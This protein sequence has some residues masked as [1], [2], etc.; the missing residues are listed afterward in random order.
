MP[1]KFGFGNYI[2]SVLDDLKDLVAHE[3][4]G[5]TTT[6]GDEG[7]GKTNLTKL[8]AY[9]VDPKIS[10]EDVAFNAAQF[11]AAVDKADE[12]SSIIWDESDDLSA[13]WAST[14]IQTLKKKFKRIRSK[15]LFIWLVTPTFFDMNKYWAIHRT[16]CLFHVYAEPK[17]DSDGHFHANRGRVRFF[18]KDNKR[19]LYFGGVKN[20]DMYCIHPDFL[21]AFNKVPDDYPINNKDYEDKK[22]EAMKSLLA[23]V[24]S[25]QSRNI[26]EILFRRRVIAFAKHIN[27]F[28]SVK[29]K[30]RLSCNDWGK[31][32]FGVNKK[33]IAN[34]IHFLQRNNVGT[35]P[36]PYYE[37]G[38]VGSEGVE[39]TSSKSSLPVVENDTEG[40]EVEP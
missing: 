20:W 35:S 11:E 29:H 9:Y 4:D 23:E 26:I 39:G 30:D 22:D 13:H 3:W 8:M 12:F 16:R 7:D 33:Q 34:D 17:R 37:G 32:F 28:D 10:I 2:K 19:K 14:M 38:R 18:G 15:H 21:D 1:T 25:K 40:G 31:L 24:S 27:W 6:V 5:V 36:N